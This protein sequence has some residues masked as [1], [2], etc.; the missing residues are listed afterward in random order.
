MVVVPCL[1]SPFFSGDG[2]IFSR[3]LIEMMSFEKGRRH[4]SALDFSSCYLLVIHL[5]LIVKVALTAGV[6]TITEWT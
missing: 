4:P 1:F 6:F 5:M 3:L 2:F